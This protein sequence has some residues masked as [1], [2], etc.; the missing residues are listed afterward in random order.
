[1]LNLHVQLKDK[2]GNEIKIRLLSMLATLFFFFF[3]FFCFFFCTVSLPV[4]VFVFLIP[5]HCFTTE[6]NGKLWLS[7]CNMI[8]SSRI[9]SE[10]EAMTMQ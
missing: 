5:F 6:T 2:C 4:A 8:H 7:L 1:M 10:G 3:F 9:S